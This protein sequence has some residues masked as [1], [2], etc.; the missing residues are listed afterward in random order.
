MDHIAV[1]LTMGTIIARGRSFTEVQQ[2]VGE[3]AEKVGCVMSEQ[4]PKRSIVICEIKHEYVL[5]AHHTL[6]SVSGG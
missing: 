5:R 3:Y 4:T 1:D 2:R 6:N